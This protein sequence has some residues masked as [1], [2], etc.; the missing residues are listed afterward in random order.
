MLRRHAHSPRATTVGTGASLAV[1][2]ALLVAGCGGSAPSG[3]R[4]TVKTE[5]GQV[6]FLKVAVFDAAGIRARV[7]RLPAMGAATLPGQ[8]ALDATDRSTPLSVLVTGIKGSTIAGA[9]SVTVPAGTGTA[10]LEL[11]LTAPG[12]DS[13]AD[14]IP[15]ALDRCR[16]VADPDQLDA[17]GDGAGD[18][19]GCRD[20]RFFSGSFSTTADVSRWSNLEAATATLIDL[21][22]GTKAMRVCRTQSS[23][24]FGATTSM[25]LPTGATEIEIS[26]LVRGTG[27]AGPLLRQSASSCDSWGACNGGGLNDPAQLSPDFA[28]Q[29]SVL[30]PKPTGALEV[31]V[32]SYDAP[33]GTCFEVKQLCVVVLK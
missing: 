21:S 6:D 28:P 25:P 20:N 18:A 12:A 2:M 10:P 19:C 29:R 3:L 16:F 23:G 5:V 14:G 4:I 7:E 22:G 9:G 13:D 24:Q 33:I 11:T 27:K 26:M 15:D 1:A 32:T 31:E 17:D 30:K 8:F